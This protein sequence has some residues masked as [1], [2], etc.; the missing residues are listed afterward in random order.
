[1]K[2][3]KKEKMKNKKKTHKIKK[4]YQEKMWQHSLKVRNC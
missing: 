4:F 2:K 3:S 1:M